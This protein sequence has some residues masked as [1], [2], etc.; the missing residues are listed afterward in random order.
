MDPGPWL[1]P[2]DT[3]EQSSPLTPDWTLPILPQSHHNIPV[4][5]LMI[6]SH[7][8]DPRS[9]NFTCPWLLRCHLLNSAIYMQVPPAMSGLARGLYCAH[10]RHLALTS[11]NMFLC[12]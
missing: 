1:H 7:L 2:L 9:R 6:L 10:S 3:A 4:S 8:R 5:I 12:S 11:Q